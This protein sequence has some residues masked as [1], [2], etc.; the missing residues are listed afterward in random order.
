[1]RR[2]VTRRSPIALDRRWFFEYFDFMAAS[3]IGLPEIANHQAFNQ[4]R[5]AELCADPALA[6]LDYRI[7][8]DRFG[9]ILMSPPPSFEHSDRQGRIL[10]KLA[11]LLGARGRARPEVPVSTTG[12][13]KAIDA[14]WISDER[15]RRA[16]K[17]QVLT[18]APEICIE[19]L[20]PSNT[21]EE[22]EETKRLYF[23]AGAEEVWICA[24]GGRMLFYC[25]D[26]LE[27]AIHLQLCPE[28]PATLESDPR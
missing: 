25:R 27:P 2:Q 5:W 26:T 17:G 1:M 19:V 13:V 20:S 4:A 16:Y 24:L 15:L 18:V 21:L 23:E 14:A 11:H 28:F 22:I 9:H 3:L 10:E 6:S 8:T 7:E 12:G